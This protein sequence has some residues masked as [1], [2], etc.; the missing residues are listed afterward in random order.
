M[1]VIG[2]RSIGVGSV[3][4]GANPLQGVFTAVNLSKPLPD[5]VYP[6]L[7][8]SFGKIIET[9]LPT[10]SGL[11]AMMLG[12]VFPF[13]TPKLSKQESPKTARYSSTA[14][15]LTGASQFFAGLSTEGGGVS[16]RGLV[17]LFS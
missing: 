1:A 14:T 13:S 8:A 16:Q 2:L 4:W 15:L 9:S 5:G 6:S 17:T 11:F 12:D 3:S 7:V 10:L